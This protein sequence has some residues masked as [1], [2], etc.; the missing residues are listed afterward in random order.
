MRQQLNL[1]RQAGDMQVSLLKRYIANIT[2]EIR[3]DIPLDRVTHVIAIGGDIRFA[4]AQLRERESD[5]T[6]TIPREEFL[7]FC[8]QIEALDEASIAD[9]FRLSAGE[10][11]SLVPALLVPVATAETAARRI[12]VSD[13]PLRGGV[14]LDMTSLAVALARLILSVR[15]GERRR[16]RR[17]LPVRRAHGRHVAM[18]RR[19]C[20]T[21]W[22]RNTV[23]RTRAP[24]LQ[25]AA[26]LHDIGAFVSLRA[27]HRHSQYLPRRRRSSTDDNETAMVANIAISPSRAAQKSHRRMSRSTGR[28]A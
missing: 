22:R 24:L 15:S 13:A 26:L 4:A 27:H 12:I 25:V 7:T 14:L 28:I 3:V 5:E 8:D 18:P 9:R 17:E 16:A 21:H 20:S 1:A 2:E 10:A 11:E 6:R 19:S 23:L